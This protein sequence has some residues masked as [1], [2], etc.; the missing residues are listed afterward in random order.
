[1]TVLQGTHLVVLGDASATR[2][3][4]SK[5]IFGFVMGNVHLNITPVTANAMKKP[6]GLAKIK[7]VSIGRHPAMNHVIMIL[8]K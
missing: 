1:M 6:S 5:L 7:L 8:L 2:Y 3:V 4:I